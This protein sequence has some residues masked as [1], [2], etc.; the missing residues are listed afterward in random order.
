MNIKENELGNSFKNIFVLIISLCIALLLGELFTRA[1]FLGIKNVFDIDS[2]SITHSAGADLI[3]T[4]AI[5]YGV[6]TGLDTSLFSKEPQP[7][8][9]GEY[10]KESQFLKPNFTGQQSDD[11]MKVW[12]LNYIKKIFSVDSLRYQKVVF[13]GYSDK[14]ILAFTPFDSTE[15]PVYKYLQ[16]STLPNSKVRFNAFGFGGSDLSL[17]KAKNTIRIAFLGGSTTQQIGGC[18]FA[19]PDYLERWLNEW[20]IGKKIDFTFEVINAGRVAQRSM[21]FEAILKY[22]ILPLRPDLV[23]YYEGRNQFW[24]QNLYGFNH[25]YSFD[26][27]LTYTIFRHSLLSQLVYQRLGLSYLKI[28]ENQKPSAKQFWPASVDINNPDPYNPYLPANMNQIV[29]DLTKIK[30]HLDS[31]QTLILSSFA[32]MAS[33]TILQS[34]NYSPIYNYWLREYGRI[35]LHDINNL[36]NYENRVF[37]NYAKKNNIPFLDVATELKKHPDI[38]TDGIHLTCEGMKLHAWIVFAQALKTIEKQLETNIII[39]TIPRQRIKEDISIVN[40]KDFEK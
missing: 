8:T 18:D 5:K 20:A 10:R 4:Y 37:Y 1:Y 28:I 21:D 7:R 3:Y 11:L 17:L 13:D 24:L 12:N 22:E 36:N 32:M 25:P 33:D 15:F 6:N 31:N 16:S 30:S 35:P 40:L 14:T 19:Y 29:N 2:K 9:Y 27:N 23:I 34:V 39:K 26:D 38:F